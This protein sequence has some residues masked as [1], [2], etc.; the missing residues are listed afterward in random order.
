[1]QCSK[2]KAAAGYC[3]STSCQVHCGETDSVAWSWGMQW[4]H[5]RGR[6]FWQNILKGTMLHLPQ[7]LDPQP[8]CEILMTSTVWSLL[9]QIPITFQL[10]K[11]NWYLHYKILTTPTC[12]AHKYTRAALGCQLLYHWMKIQLFYIQSP[13]DSVMHQSIPMMDDSSVQCVIM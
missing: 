6:C 13:H 7:V 8:G 9:L 10:Q 2:K 4:C 5:G 3:F 12:N 11:A 1:M